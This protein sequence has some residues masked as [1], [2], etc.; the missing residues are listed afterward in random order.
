M[1]VNLPQLSIDDIE[2]MDAPVALFATGDTSEALQ[3]AGD[4]IVIAIVFHP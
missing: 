3:I 2:E 4:H 1:P